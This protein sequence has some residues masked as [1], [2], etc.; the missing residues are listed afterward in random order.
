MSA[1]SNTWLRRAAW[2]LETMAADLDALGKVL[3]KPHFTDPN[4][5]AGMAARTTSTRPPITCQHIA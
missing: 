5:K 3:D 4:W 2:T 1:T